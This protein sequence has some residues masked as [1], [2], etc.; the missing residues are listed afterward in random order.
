MHEAR[1]WVSPEHGV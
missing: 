1:D